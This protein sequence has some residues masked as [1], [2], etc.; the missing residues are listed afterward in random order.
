MKKYVMA[1]S[2]LSLVLLAACIGTKKP[3]GIAQDKKVETPIQE[4]SVEVKTITDE[5]AMIK[6]EDENEKKEN[7]MMLVGEY[8]DHTADN[9]PVAVLADGTT[10]VLFFHAAWCPSCRKANQTLTSWYTNGNDLLTTY[11]INY[12]EEKELE[13]KYGVI[14]QHT[15]VKVDGQGN[16]IEKIQAPTDDQLM[17][18]LRK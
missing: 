5:E 9:L 3:S 15:F 1:L 7:A 17:V 11:A 10:K 18:L 6:N 12:D 13:Q 16:M 8:K 2:V 14:Y 4:D